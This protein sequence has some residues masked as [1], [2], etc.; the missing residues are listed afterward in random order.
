MSTTA[1]FQTSRTATL[2]P[3]DARNKKQLRAVVAAFAEQFAAALASRLVTY[4]RLSKTK[5]VTSDT[6][7]VVAEELLGA[8]S[9]S[10]PDGLDES[11]L[12]QTIIYSRFKRNLG[13]LRTDSKCASMAA[14]VGAHFLR[15]VRDLI[16]RVFA[17]AEEPRAITVQQV[18]ASLE[19]PGKYSPSGLPCLAYRHDDAIFAQAEAAA[20]QQQ[21]DEAAQA[22]A[23]PAQEK[24]KGKKRARKEEAVAAP[25]PVAVVVEEEKAK[26]ARAPKKA[27][28]A[29]AAVAEAP[30]VA[31]AAA[32]EAKKRRAPAKK[33]SAAA[34]GVTA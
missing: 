19:R 3:V 25:E 20:P 14:V 17:G 18:I 2:V 24:A 1:I 16:D 22:V 27:K 29:T 10:L 8:G 34:A 9:T 28:Q 32:P 11:R 7:Q 33:A 12:P 5:T 23:A 30:V 4:C 15:Y 21:Q 13:G 31:E 26:K 6:L